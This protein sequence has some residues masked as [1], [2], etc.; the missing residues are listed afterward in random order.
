MTER[1]QKVLKRVF[2]LLPY[3]GIKHISEKTELPR[4]TV[5]DVFNNYRP[6]RRVDYQLVFKTTHDFLREMG[7]VY[8]PLKN[9]LTKNI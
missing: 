5:V 7:V 4:S 2:K 3:S 8:I 1:D 6:N 9:L